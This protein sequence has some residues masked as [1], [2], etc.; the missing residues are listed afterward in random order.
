MP[1][2]SRLTN[3]RDE[4][5]MKLHPVTRDT[6]QVIVALGGKS[7]R[8]CTLVTRA[9]KPERETQTVSQILKH[10]RQSQKQFYY[11]VAPGDTI[12]T[13]LGSVKIKRQSGLPVIDPCDERLVGYV[14]RDL[15]VTSPEDAVL[16]KDVMTESPI[17][18]CETDSLSTARQVMEKFNMET[19]PVVSRKDGRCIGVIHLAEIMKKKVDP[20]LER[21]MSIDM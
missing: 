20:G 6:S 3:S 12:D 17:S 16:V 9:G 2:L 15:L 11:T 21:D 18:V 4:F 5:K 7:R 10:K 19:L 1:F 8:A 13:I 14:D